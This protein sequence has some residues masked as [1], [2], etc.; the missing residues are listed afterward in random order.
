MARRKVLVVG[1]LDSIHLYRWIKQFR[2]QEID[3]FLFPSKKFRSIRPELKKLILANNTMR[4]KLPFFIYNL[5][6]IGYIDY[7]FNELRFTRRL[8]LRKTAL[9]WVLTNHKFDFVHAL[10]IQGAGYL[11]SSIK[12]STL[13]D[14]KLILTN[15]GSDIFYFENFSNNKEKIN[16]VLKIADF[17]SAECARDYALVSKYNFLGKFLPCIP[18]SG[19]FDLQELSEFTLPT[20]ERNLIIVKSYGGEF[21]ATKLVFPSLIESLE[22]YSN[23]SVHF[24]SVTKDLELDIKNFQS[25]YPSRVTYST[26]VNPLSRTQMID[27]FKLARIYIGSSLSDGLSTSFLESIVFGAFP[28]QTNTSCA[29]EL[30]EKGA[31]GITVNLNSQEI[32]VAVKKALSDND[33]VNDAQ[34]RNLQFARKFLSSEYV[35]DQ[36]K[37]FYNL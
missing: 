4:I 28:I 30:L 14:N 2:S 19:G 5:S 3:F 33:Y 34:A 6:I 7:F 21:G 8:N 18:N 29:N 26:V 23:I 37:L 17:Y 10:E 25:Q 36:A 15:W 16:N 20:A 13:S 31:V 12:K 22:N 1:M 32:Q 9:A 11:Y 24:Y 27:F 35:F